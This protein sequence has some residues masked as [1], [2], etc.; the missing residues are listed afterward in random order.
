MGRRQN[1]KSSHT[2]L[3]NK[4]FRTTS[5]VNVFCKTWNFWNLKFT[6]TRPL[7]LLNLVIF[8]SQTEKLSLLTV[9][10]SQLISVPW[11]HACVL[12]VRVCACM[13]AC[14]LC[15]CVCACVCVHVC[16][17]DVW[18]RSVSYTFE[19]F[20]V[21]VCVVCVWG[22]VCLSVWCFVWVVYVS[23]EHSVHWWVHDK[24]IQWNC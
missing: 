3:E 1:A 19:F 14:V 17:N 12:C 10:S 13:H 5:D 16:V 18:Y 22:G 2:A 6:S 11:Y 24:C 20:V 21:C 23:C 7:T 4:K 8:K 15:V 9:F